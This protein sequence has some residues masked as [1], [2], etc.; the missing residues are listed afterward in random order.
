[1]NLRQFLRPWLRSLLSVCGVLLIALGVSGAIAPEAIA[2]TSV[3][4]SDLSYHECPAEFSEGAVTSMGSEA[5]SC[6][7]ITGTAT[8]STNK[9]VI[10]ADVFGRIY[11]RNGNSVFQNRTR[12][13]LIPEVPP[14]KSTFEVR[15]TVDARQKPPLQLKQFKASGFTA[16]VR[17]FY[18]DEND[19]L[20]N[21]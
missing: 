5:A 14:G 15:I 11:D 3:D 12:V 4:L 6:Y 10:D 8:N 2:L 21:F 13:G 17:P 1:M 20:T 16:R 19:E 18:Y 7:I 9:Y